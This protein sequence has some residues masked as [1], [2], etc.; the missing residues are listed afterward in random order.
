MRLFYTAKLKIESEFNSWLGMESGLTYSS[1]IV[2]YSS[3]TWI[4]L[5]YYGIKQHKK[6][7]GRVRLNIELSLTLITQII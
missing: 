1:R 3:F 6:G 2:S 4:I 7:Y 5:V